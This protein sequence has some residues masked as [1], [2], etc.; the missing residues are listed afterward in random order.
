MFAKYCVL[1]FKPDTFHPHPELI[2]SGQAPAPVRSVPLIRTCVVT[3]V[4]K[5]GTAD[6]LLLDA[7]AGNPVVPMV[8]VKRGGP[9]SPGWFPNGATPQSAADT[10]SKPA[11]SRK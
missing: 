6:L 8:A 10:P 5:D 7:A 11:R 1:T 9:D 3:A 4:H 2:K